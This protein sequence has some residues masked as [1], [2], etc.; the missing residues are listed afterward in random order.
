MIS[1]L[2]DGKPFEVPELVAQRLGEYY[3]TMIKATTEYNKLMELTKKVREQQQEY[4]K[5]RDTYV[6]RAS[7]AKEKELDDYLSGK[8]E[9]K[10]LQAE[11]FR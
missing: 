7:K 2:I 5:T 10:Q 1:I 6:L 11:L 4:F 9:K 8:S 3:A